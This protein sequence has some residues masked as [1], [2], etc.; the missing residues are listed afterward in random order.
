[1]IALI[2]VGNSVKLNLFLFLSW[3][4]SA[5]CNCSQLLDVILHMKISSNT[6]LQIS[7]SS[8]TWIYRMFLPFQVT[9]F[10]CCICLLSCSP[11]HACNLCLFIFK[12]IFTE[13]LAVL[14][15]DAMIVLISEVFVDW[16]K[17]AFILKFNE[18]PADVRYLIYLLLL[19]VQAF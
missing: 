8:M 14:L 12:F 2:F 5:V 4:E 7:V 17:H 15:P 13:H 16:G 6:K 11:L 10:K 18:I 9:R 1:M 3:W 19:Y